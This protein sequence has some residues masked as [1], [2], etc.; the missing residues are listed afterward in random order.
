MRIKTYRS[1]SRRASL[2]TVMPPTSS[3]SS[4]LRSSITP[5]ARVPSRASR[6]L[7]LKVLPLLVGGALHGLRLALGGLSGLLQRAV[8]QNRQR[9]RRIR[10]DH[11][12]T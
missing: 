11:L 5:A 9:Q 2:R 7:D 4:R 12:R 1:I 6:R 8:G 10:N 3:P